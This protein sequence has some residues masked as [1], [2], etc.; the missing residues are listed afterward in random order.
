MLGDRLSYRLLPVIML[1]AGR[2]LG[3][4]SAQDFQPVTDSVVINE[5]AWSGTGAS[6][7]HEWIELHNAGDQSL[8][9]TGWRLVA[10]DGQPDI[11]LVGTIAPHGFFLMESGDDSP[12]A[13]IPADQVFQGTLGDAGE[14]LSLRN[15]NGIQVDTA[16]GDG[17]FW[18]AGTGH[19][20]FRA[21]E[22]SNPLQP[23]ADGNWHSNNG[24]V[25]NGHDEDGNPINGTPASSNS[26]PGP[27]LPTATPLPTHT[28]TETPAPTNTPTP[29]PTSTPYSDQL[30]L[31]EFMP[32]PD[33]DW[34]DDG[35]ADE[36][37]EY[38]ELF[39][40][41]A[42]PLDVSGWQLDDR[43]EGGSSPYVLPA[44]SWIPARGFL[45]A[46]RSESNLALNNSGGD[47]VRLLRPDGLL[48]E[49]FP[50]TNGRDD[51]AYSKTVDG[52]GEWVRTYP[53]SPGSS[54]QPPPTATPTAT[55][56]TAT[57]AG[58]VFEDSDED[59]VYEPWHG[60]TGIANVL[61][62]LSDGRSKLTGPTGWYGWHNLPPDDY[63]VWQAQPVHS[64]SSTPDQLTVTL[65]AG[66]FH[67]N[68]NFGEIFLP[69]SQIQPP[70][71]LNEFLP[72]PSS[73]WDGDGSASAEDE[74]VELYN[75]SDQ[76]MDVG[77]WFLDDVDDSPVRLPTGSAPY[78]IP[79]G[80]LILPQS[81][82]VIYRS[83]SRVALNN[84]GDT[85]RLLGPGQYEVEAFSYGS[86]GYD[87]AWAKTVEGGEQWTDGYPPSPGGVNGAGV[88]PSPS[89]TATQTATASP[90]VSPTPGP[91]F[92]P[93]PT[94]TP[95]ATA[96]PYP[97]VD[98][99][100]VMV[101]L[102][103]YMPD[104]ATDWNGDGESDQGD[105]YIELYNG[106][107]EAVHLGGWILD[108]VEDG[109]VEGRLMA[110][111]GSSPYVISPGT[112]I[113][114]GGYLLFF[115]SDTRLA[116]NNTGDWVRLLQPDGREV[117]ATEYTTSRDDEAYSKRVDGGDEWTRH[118]Q[119]SPGGSNIPPPVTLTPIP[120]ATLTPSPT[121]TPSA[122]PTGSPSPT[123]TPLATATPY[124]TVDPGSVMVFL[125]E[126][127]P[128]PATDWNGDG[129]SDQGDEYIEL[130]NGG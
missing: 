34:N 13:D 126:Y 6:G 35:T 14:I 39:N 12:V 85:V 1:L 129:E 31:N 43:A 48:V 86:T 101:F 68:V 24:L 113:T 127:M 105:E 58:W 44:G 107:E 88:T 30:T 15:A 87:V 25:R 8:D 27:P 79:P 49:E 124:P 29:E 128:D 82:L 67:D 53:P 94:S 121:H 96:T 45:L 70:V 106:G 9:I 41:S 91:S 54:N 23:D 102:N 60:E 26:P 103:E 5:V 95:L 36:Q 21:M 89:P 18:P 38:I 19:P 37:D 109:M 130:Y 119:P 76:T 42:L 57:L 71:S 90:S 116:L 100:S 66:Q 33:S 112:V 51:E 46:F 81:Y 115:R 62:I 7:H 69:P 110:P 55:P 83:S 122:S 22:R 16:N 108:D 80:T 3:T 20:G 2:L 118:Y 77:G 120:T 11:A 99:G 52:G 84:S 64:I 4:P 97:T 72:S 75:D 56:T 125:N 117:E 47:S 114:P 98:P 40:G 111:Q 61:V 104:P 73:D 92:T 10:A 65:V 78:L 59:G 28:P 50:Y 63:T 93:S 32:N 123:S 17:G 74:W